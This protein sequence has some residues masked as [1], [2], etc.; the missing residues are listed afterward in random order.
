M[1]VEGNDEL[2]VGLPFLLK[3]VVD[4]YQRKAAILLPKPINDIIY[5]IHLF[6]F[7]LVQTNY[8]W[9]IIQA[10]ALARAH[11]R[12][13]LCLLLVYLGDGAR[14][15]VQLHGQEDARVLAVLLVLVQEVVNCVVSVHFYAL[16]RQLACGDDFVGHEL[17]ESE[18]GPLVD[19]VEGQQV[20]CEVQVK[21]VGDYV[22]EHVLAVLGVDG[23]VQEV[24]VRDDPDLVIKQLY[25]VLQ[26]LLAAYQHI[27]AYIMA[28]AR[29]SLHNLPV[30]LMIIKLE[31][32]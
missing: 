27:Q 25:E 13:H 1:F 23:V 22:L 26:V 5:L 11:D 6:A 18:L 10:E 12:R 20:Y 28:N 24:L 9:Q 7:D 29:Y 31:V 8:S 16:V 21:A 2:A 19:D 14:L 15:A 4:P 30:G 17:D 3:L 32:P